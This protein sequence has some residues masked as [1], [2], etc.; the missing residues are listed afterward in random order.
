MPLE[1]GINLERLAYLPRTA[2][3]VK[4]VPGA[5]KQLLE[6]HIT[7]I[8]DRYKYWQ[9]PTESRT[10]SGVR[11]DVHRRGTTFS[12]YSESDNHE[13]RET[14]GIT[15][16]GSYGTIERVEIAHQAPFAN[17]AGGIRAMHTVVDLRRGLR[18]EQ[19]VDPSTFDILDRE[20]KRRQEFIFDTNSTELATLTW[21]FPGGKEQRVSIITPTEE[22]VSGVIRHD[23]KTS[24]RSLDVAGGVIYLVTPDEFIS[25]GI[26][27]ALKMEPIAFQ[28][29]R[30]DY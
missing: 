22:V 13:E 28:F 26:K 6:P 21:I 27:K 2:T 30:K 25:G 12:F 11:Y 10:L 3:A 16:D 18:I 8:K 23:I 29:V 7:F 20:S 19:E 4:E 5:L 14:I 15:M 17:V 24:R 1:K 9:G